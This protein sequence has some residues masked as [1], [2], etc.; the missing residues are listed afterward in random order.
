MPRSSTKK[1]STNQPGRWA[2]QDAKAQFSELVRKAQSDGPQHVTV[3]GRDS[4]VV[5]SVEEFRRLKGEPTGK[6]LVDLMAN[7]PLRDVD[8]ERRSTKGK[9]RDFEL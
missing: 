5:I 9:V 8:F 4:V 2:L 6:A 3:H 7:S 1:T